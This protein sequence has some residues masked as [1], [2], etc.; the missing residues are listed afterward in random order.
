MKME[1]ELTDSQAEKVEVLKNNDLSVGD[2]I[3][4]LF[5][6]KE[7]L[8]ENSMLFIDSKISNANKEKE[9]LQ[10]RMDEIDD[11]IS[12]FEKLKDTS[13]D[14]E[15]VFKLVEKEY[16]HN[17]TYDRAVQNKK[18]KFKWSKNIFKL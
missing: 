9:E 15:Q 5:D 7:E 12:V 14:Y 1:I 17:E 4:M 6:L 18:H 3:D 11:E 10:K 2:A 8:S 13:L 16:L